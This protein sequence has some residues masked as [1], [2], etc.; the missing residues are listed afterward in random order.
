MTRSPTMKNRKTERSN[1]LMSSRHKSM[2]KSVV[3]AEEKSAI[4]RKRPYRLDTLKI[5]K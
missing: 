3:N 2:S 1:T 4:S 5:N